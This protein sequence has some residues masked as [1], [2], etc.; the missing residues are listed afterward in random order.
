MRIQT[1]DD[2]F[3]E[4][5]DS[6]DNPIIFGLYLFI[7]IILS[8]IWIPFWCIGKIATLITKKP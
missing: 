8:P 5:I 2:F 4:H 6:K 1:M 3:D 7:I